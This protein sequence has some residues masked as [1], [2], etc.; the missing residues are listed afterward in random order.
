[1]FPEGPPYSNI[2]ERGQH[3]E[4]SDGDL[5]GGGD[6]DD[7]GGEVLASLGEGLPSTEGERRHLVP[8]LSSIASK[9]RAE[10]RNPKRE[11][12]CEMAPNVERRR[13]L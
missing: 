3:K 9:S 11:K 6:L 2:G 7:A 12:E 5:G 13:Y 8:H 4:T 1:M 10:E